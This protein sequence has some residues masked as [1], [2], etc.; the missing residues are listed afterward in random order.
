MTTAPRPT[1]AATAGVG[2]SPPRISRNLVIQLT[3]V[4]CVG[5]ALA[6]VLTWVWVVPWIA[7]VVGSS[8]I[9]DSLLRRATE[10]G[11]SGRGLRRTAAAFRLLSSTFW[12]FAALALVARGDGAERLLAFALLAVPTVDRKSAV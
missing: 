10:A 6:H 12:A 8:W 9:E 7:G 1:L 5:L 4:A 11:A 2:R 3:G